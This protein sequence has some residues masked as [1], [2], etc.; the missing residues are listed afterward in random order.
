[1]LLGFGIWVLGFSSGCSP[2]PPVPDALDDDADRALGFYEQAQTLMAQEPPDIASA[3]QY[4]TLAL[5]HD[6]GF[7][8]A[9]FGR[10]RALAAR[11]DHAA[12]EGDFAHA[13]E[14]AG[15]DKAALYHLLRARY[16]HAERRQLERA[17]TDY[18]AAMQWQERRPDPYLVDVLL[19]RAL[20]YL[21]TGR[22]DKAIRDYERVI[23]LNPD[24]ETID[25][26]K[27]MIGIARRAATSAAGTR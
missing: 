1:M 11:G 2:V 13:V 21:D 4:Y 9:W 20:L 27:N 26:V 16:F 23:S 6:A 19:H 18:D 14:T 10:A 17:E 15:P 25:Q 7:T 3:V 5:Q 12:A 22:P 24:P 8:Q